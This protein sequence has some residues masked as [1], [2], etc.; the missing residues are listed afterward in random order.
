MKPARS[1]M[2]DTDS[3]V[4]RYGDHLYG[5]SDFEGAMGCYLK[6]VGTVQAS[7]VIRKVRDISSPQRDTYLTLSAVPRR[8]ATISPH[9]VSPRTPFP[10]S[11]Q[12]RPHDS[13]PQLLHQARRRHCPLI[14]PPL[15]IQH[16]TC[17]SADWI[18]FRQLS[19]RRRGTTVR[20]GDC[21]SS[22]STSRLLRACCLAR[23]ALRG[24][25]GI[26]SYPNRGSK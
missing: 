24:T 12:F 5:R 16:E 2:K 25:S 4:D 9:F 26:P 21:H 17:P 8:P 22:L 1:V 7:Y 11:R 3:R 6:T 18:S 10:R 13:P 23:S 14:V 20:L 15:V 19:S